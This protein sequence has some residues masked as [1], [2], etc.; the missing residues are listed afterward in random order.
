MP[1]PVGVVVIAVLEFLGA[2][3]M[4]LGGLIAL[5]GMGF[6]ARALEQ[7]GTINSSMVPVVVGA[8]V[9]VAVFCFACAVFFGFLGYGMLNLR[10]WARIATLVLAVL[11]I[12]LG[13]LGIVGGLFRFGIISAVFS[14]I[15]VAVNGLIFW[16]LTQPHIKEAFGLGVLPAPGGMTGPTGALR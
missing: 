7:N 11:G 12:V 6:L 2:A 15:R 13:I 3:G 8:G 4:A 10:N 9:L 5:F 14:G 16:Y 1:R